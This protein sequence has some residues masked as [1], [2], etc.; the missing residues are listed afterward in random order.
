MPPFKP[1]PP[2]GSNNQIN[3]V[4]GSGATIEMV[5]AFSAL[6]ASIARIPSANVG[7]VPQIRSPQAPQAFQNALQ[8]ANR[9]FQV[10]K[11]LHI[12]N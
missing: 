12:N 7:T 11:K 9:R 2:K 5:P 6:P 8:M 4:S 3:R 10:F 1:L